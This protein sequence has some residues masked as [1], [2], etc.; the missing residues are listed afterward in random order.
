[1]AT[2]ASALAKK[3]L[4]AH[5]DVT[6]SNAGTP[7]PPNN[8]VHILL[9]ATGS[10]AT[11]KLPLI[12]QSLLGYQNVEVQVVATK[13]AKR[14]FDADKL[15]RQGV[16]VWV[17]DDE[18]K[19]WVDVKDHILHIELR[20]WAHL[21]LIAPMSANT[22]AKMANGICDNLLVCTSII[23][24]WN[25]HNPILIAPAMNTYMYSHPITAK[26]LAYVKENMPWVQI[27]QP[28]EK[29]LACGDIGMGGMCE[30]GEIVGKVSRQFQ[31]VQ[32]RR[33]SFTN[34]GDEYTEVRMG[35]NAQDEED[36]RME[37]ERN[38]KDSL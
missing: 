11:V 31:L 24:A 22:L 6:S 36:V 25:T 16:K 18:W 13:H 34:A 29:V 38:A 37:E 17:D 30:W 12:T 3:A 28:I 15:L 1:M 20:R 33:S 7:S 26:H 2:T 35:N 4:H 10:V 27:I 8:N 32:R 14:F 5:F 19:N 9:A 23:R 21:L